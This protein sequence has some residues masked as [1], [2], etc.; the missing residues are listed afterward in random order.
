MHVHVYLLILCLQY[1]HLLISKWN[2]RKKWKEVPHC[3]KI[4]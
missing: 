2:R 1:L 4:N 3:P